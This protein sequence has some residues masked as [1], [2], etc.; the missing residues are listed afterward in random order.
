MQKS[1]LRK[2]INSLVKKKL[3]ASTIV[4]VIVALA[5]C[6]IIFLIA[7]N[8]IVNSQRSNNIRLKQKA[9][10]ILSTLNADVQNPDSVFEN[11]S[12]HLETIQQF[13]DT[14]PGVCRLNY[15]VM[16][17]AGHVLATKVIWLATDQ[18]QMEE[19]EKSN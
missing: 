19:K 13:N 2:F 18:L 15:V 11:G 17:N 7:M 16:D 5:I 8:V 4:E 9:Q 3:F 1:A 12:L 6:M 10:F 14:I